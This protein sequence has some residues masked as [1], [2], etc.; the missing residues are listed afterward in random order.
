MA[1]IDNSY[2]GNFA[3]LEDMVDP[4]LYPLEDVHVDDSA[5]PKRR[6]RTLSSSEMSIMEK[7]FKCVDMLNHVESSESLVSS[8]STGSL[9]RSNSDVSIDE[10]ITAKFFKAVEALTL[11]SY[12]SS[13]SLDSMTDVEKNRT[14]WMPTPIENL[15]KALDEFLQNEPISRNTSDSTLSRR[16]SSSGNLNDDASV[17]SD[18]IATPFEVLMSSLDQFLRNGD[19]AEDNDLDD[20]LRL[21]SLP[22]PIE[23]IANT[24]EEFVSN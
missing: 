8:S 21:G 15:A 1:D 5:I 14:K 4:L 9:H 6:Q 7:I 17:P 22:G 10:T 12:A 18:L 24:F 23:K 13:A 3:A 16:G 11:E 20:K 2:Y 19:R